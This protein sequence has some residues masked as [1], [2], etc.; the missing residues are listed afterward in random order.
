MGHHVVVSDDAGTKVSSPLTQLAEMRADV[1]GR[2][3]PVQAVVVGG[4]CLEVVL[5]DVHSVARAQCQ[6]RRHHPL[7]VGLAHLS[8]PRPSGATRVRTVVS[9]PSAP[10]E[11]E[12]SPLPA[13]QHSRCGEARHVIPRY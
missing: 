11:V 5:N 7:P 8:G 2:T 10:P 12:C 13:V 6:R 9:S 4:T 3:S 1:S